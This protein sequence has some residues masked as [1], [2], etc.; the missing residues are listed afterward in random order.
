[1]LQFGRYGA[2]G[3]CF[4]QM[5]ALAIDSRLQGDSYEHHAANSAVSTSSSIARV[6]NAIIAEGED[7]I[8][9]IA[10]FPIPHFAIV[11]V[12]TSDS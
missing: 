2:Q 6:C 12:A 7:P 1:M 9:E 10:P 11:A 5:H 8:S 3:S 4:I